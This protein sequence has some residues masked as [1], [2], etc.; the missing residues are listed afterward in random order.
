MKRL[1]ALVLCLTM[2]ASAALADVIYGEPGA[3]PIANE[4]VTVRIFAPQDGEYSRAENLQTKEPEEKLGVKI[5]W[6]IAPHRQH[7]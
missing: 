7:P 3:A 2:L 4:V 5:E 1:L 6:V